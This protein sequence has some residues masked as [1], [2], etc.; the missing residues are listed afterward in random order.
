MTKTQI[1]KAFAALQAI[2]APVINKP[3]W[4]VISGEDNHDKDTKEFKAWA[5]ADRDFMHPDITAI[6][7]KHGLTY[8]WYDGG[9]AKIHAI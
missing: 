8:E 9:T 2:G 4:F 1:K 3:D 7:K 6:L 5:F